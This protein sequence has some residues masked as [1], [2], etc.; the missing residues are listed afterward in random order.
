MELAVH[1]ISID[2]PPELKAALIPRN[3]NGWT[4]NG[5]VPGPT[6]TALSDAL[7]AF[8][9]ECHRLGLSVTSVSIKTY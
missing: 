1:G 5:P 4:L 7:Q 9:D 6:L 8:Q 2:A 3:P